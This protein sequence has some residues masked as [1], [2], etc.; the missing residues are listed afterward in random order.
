VWKRFI[1]LCAICLCF[2]G[3]AAA[4]D[5]DSTR[6]SPVVALDFELVTGF[7]EEM[8]GSVMLDR[9]LRA[10]CRIRD[11]RLT[12]YS[13]SF[14]KRTSCRFVA[15]SFKLELGSGLVFGNSGRFFCYTWRRRPPS[16]HAR[17][18][19]SL[20]FWN[21][22][23]GAA[24]SLQA[25]GVDSHIALF[26]KPDASA[27]G[28]PRTALVAI[29]S[30]SSRFVS[31]GAILI[32][33]NP[34]AEE[35]ARR[36]SRIPLYHLFA[37]AACGELFLSGEFDLLAGKPF[38]LLEIGLS[39][40]WRA[41]MKLFR[42]P[43]LKDIGIWEQAGSNQFDEFSGIAFHLESGRSGIRP[44]LWFLSTIRSLD[45]RR[46]AE[47]ACEL[48]VS[49]R[50]GGVCRWNLESMLQETHEI[51][52]PSARWASEASP[53][54][55]RS[56]RLRSTIS[57]ADRWY[58]HTVRTTLTFDRLTARP[59]DASAAVEMRLMRPPFTVALKF[60]SYVLE[61]G[62]P[63]M[64]FRP[65]VGA[66]EH[67]SLVYGRGSDLCVRVAAALGSGITLSGYAGKPWRKSER[68]YAAIRWKF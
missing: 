48:R 51:E 59:R 46:V 68:I 11:G 17:F 25:L 7:D 3:A 42:A 34:D 45:T 30:C 32:S 62:D 12:W 23:V 49:G 1:R 14:R 54:T 16:R 29:S 24:V 44:S 27:G 57:L 31:G 15:G 65:G 64:L 26:E 66:F 40:P 37:S 55:I 13:A 43:D 36:F 19:P 58:Q 8:S 2:C 61:P 63:I 9:G 33:L 28:S 39:A 47:R 6:R 60:Q 53:A 50:S 67:W 56:A 20:S 41:G 10:G 4:A 5:P 18:A 35:I 22:Q 38:G 52:Y 21:R